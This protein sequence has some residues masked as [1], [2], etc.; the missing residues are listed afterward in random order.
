MDKQHH[1]VVEQRKHGGRELA[2]AG[3]GLA[4][5][6]FL[7]VGAWGAFSIQSAVRDARRA[8]H[9]RSDYASLRY[10]AAV[11]RRSI[12][13]AGSGSSAAVSFFAA[14]RGA[15]QAIDHLEASGRA[16]DRDRIVRVSKL[17]NEALSR[18]SRVFVS[19]GTARPASAALRRSVAIRLERLGSLGAAG[20][21]DLRLR[22]AG[23]W[24]GSPA[25]KAALAVTL[26]VFAL[27]LG[28]GASPLVRL[29]G[30]RRVRKSERQSQLARL[31]E[32]ALTDSLT[33]LRNH[34]AFHEDFKREIA[35]RNRTGSAFSLLMVD[36]NGLKQINDAHGHQAGDERINAVGA[37]LTASF[38]GCDSAYR[39]GGDEFAVILRDQRAWG[40][41]TAA[42]R[43]HAEVKKRN[44]FVGVTVGVS[45]SVATESKDSLIR[46]ADIAL[47][48]AK[49]SHLNTIVYSPG[50]EP[51]QSD[52]DEEAQRHHQK[53]LATALARA[54]DAKDAGTRNH[55]ETVSELCAMIGR[56]LGLQPSRIEK[57][58]V[59]GLLHDVGKIGIADS[60]LLKPEELESDESEVMRTHSA[61]GHNIV[62]A[63]ELVDE[64]GWVLHHHEWFDG[65]GYPSGL[66]GEEIPLESRIILVADAFEAITAD[67]PYRAGR[68]P[69]EGLDELLANVGTQFDGAC[70][71]ALCSLFGAEAPT[72]RPEAAADEFSLR[73]RGRGRAE[74]APLAVG[75]G[76]A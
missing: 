32:F 45:E 71:T 2:R 61:I 34:R 41:L 9:L 53:V 7:T 10:Y 38:R 47:Y 36:L 30:F 12:Q 48:E 28:A 17:Q 23:S 5:L 68:T 44:G 66:A 16:L 15:G 37:C 75:S 43:L 62:S 54:V 67:R 65:S 35:R 63:A 55:C 13:T 14:A 6:A 73:R 46:Q 4:V 3:A 70:V 64:A 1:K 22:Q 33:G 11:E 76:S 40:A 27:G 51:T 58:R 19:A 29:V 56:K 60:I 20:T 26:L 72:P 25:D 49:R 52:A 8:S 31:E 18:A 42:Q 39:I 57:L 59:A 69:Q 74:G 50:M 24:P 21:S